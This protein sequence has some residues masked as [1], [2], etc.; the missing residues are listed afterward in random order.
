MVGFLLTA[1]V[2]LATREIRINR[3]PFATVKL[4][5][6]FPYFDNLPRKLM[7]RDQRK[8][9][10]IFTTVYVQIRATNPNLG[11]L[12]DDLVYST[13]GIGHLF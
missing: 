7:T 5:D 3:Y 13:R 12:H 11:D 6:A 10:E 4:G 8:G 2:A 1:E 9:A